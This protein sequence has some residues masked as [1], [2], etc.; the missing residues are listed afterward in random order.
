MDGLAKTSA[1]ASA[2]RPSAGP[3][4]ALI[5][6]AAATLGVLVW[7]GVS[8]SRPTRRVDENAV[9]RLA[10]AGDF[11]GAEALLVGALEESKEDARAHFLLAQ[12]LID[13]TDVPRD[14]I[15][16]ELA[17]RA[18]R[19]VERAAALDP[20]GSTVP[21]AEIWLYRGKGLYQLRRWD[22]AE[23]AW[24]AALRVD[25]RVPE[26]GW[27]LLDLYYLEGRRDD[28]RRLALRLFEVEPDPRDRA[29]LLLE[30]VRQDAVPVSGE[31]LVPQ[32]EAAVAAEPDAV[33]SAIGLAQALIRTS[34]PDRG[35]A[36]LRGLT[37]R[38]P[39]DIE[40]W[41][42]LMLGL[43]QAARPEE[44]PKALASV[45]EELRGA[46]RLARGRALAAQTEGRWADAARELEAVVAADPTD[47][48]S[49][50][51]LERALRFSGRAEEADAWAARVTRHREAR[52]GLLALYD[53][54][55]AAAGLGVRPHEELCERLAAARE[56]MG[57]VEEAERWRVVGRGVR[58]NSG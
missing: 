11:A 12:L 41:A 13:R 52:Q 49:Q 8:A 46:P 38:R 54:A 20:G 37:E 10:A 2:E 44:I 56:A 23:A 45:P 3:P 25:P 57:R 55:N 29:Q 39:E 58:R 19:H 14:R 47:F 34:D 6:A 26:A 24:R 16:T 43:D 50:T 28:A 17:A 15:D 21:R 1:E 36:I 42:A 48:E 27:S 7:L 40:T 51:R 9:A 31:S 18:L 22:E 4:W 33:R 5:V 30:L 35:L 53:E 32:F